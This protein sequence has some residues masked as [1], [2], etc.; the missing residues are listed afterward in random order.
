[1]RVA[2]VEKK[3]RRRNPPPPFMT[4]TLQQDSVRKLG[5]TAHRTM[6][7]AQ[8]LYEGV[9]VGGASV[10]LITYMRTDSLTLAGEAIGELRTFIAERFGAQSLPG[11]ARVYKTKSKNA[12]EAHEA[13]RPTSAARV[14]EKLRSSLS[15]DQYKLYQLIWKRTVA[16]QMEHAL[17]DTVAV[18]LTGGELEPA[19]DAAP[20]VF[21]A[22][23]S[24]VA[25]PGFLAV[26]D[27][28]ED[29]SGTESGERRLP[30][31]ELGD[32]VALTRL[33]P[34]QHFTE[35]PPRYSE[36]SLI[37]ALEEYGIGRPS[38]YAA[39]IQTLQNREYVELDR[40]RF[41]PTDIGRVV[42]GYLTE[43]FSTYVD[44]EFTAR[45]E[46]DLDAI[47]R[48]ERQW[49]PL[50]RDFWSA[51]EQRVRSK[52]AESGRPAPRELGL[53]PKSGRPVTVRMGRYGPYVQIGTAA[54]DD[55]PKFA[56]LRP[57]QRMNDITL[58][59][60]LPLFKLPRGLGEMLSG[61]PVSVN[62]GRYGPY[63]KYGSKFVSLASDD[64]PHTITLER[65][66]EL[67]EGQEAGRRP[68]RHQGVRGRRR[69][70]PQWT[71]RAIRHRWQEERARAQGSRAV[72]SQPRGVSRAAG[73]GPGKS[74]KAAH[75][76]EAGHQEEASREEKAFGKV[77]NVEVLDA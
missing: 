57:G 75:E 9:A 2:K 13:I 5:F 19:L 29:E 36:A 74:W 21:R 46:D 37:R 11:S 34:E 12:Q 27:E 22:T 3:Q 28:G 69:P 58:E 77:G 53:D 1:M 8:Q 40:R 42:N 35:P 17:I 72:E 55:K 31:L 65:A 41:R 50:M 38:T 51:F 47:S 49:K 10:G 71:L 48:G 16:C 60:A 24:S 43:H 32:I 54:D 7:V 63:V 39:I 66:L 25:S 76:E 45:L 18:D 73:G 15:P 30:V 68:A 33:R 4:S 14:P 59:E 67:I 6:R 23:G 26:Y 62:I 44:Y 52:E 61:E 70:D 20:E 64:D 56:G